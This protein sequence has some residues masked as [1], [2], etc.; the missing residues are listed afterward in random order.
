MGEGFWGRIGRTFP[1][2]K[3]RNFRLFWFGQMI[4]LVGTWIQ[5]V[6][7]GWLVLELTNNS[8]FKLG[9]VTML[10][11]LPILLFSLYAGA[12]VERHPKR[13][14]LLVTQSLLTVLAAVLATLVYTGVVQ[15]WHVLLLAF[16]LGSTN[17]FDMPAR[18]S[19]Y[20]EVV[21][22]EAL[23]SAISLNSMIFNLGR[24]LGP[25]LAA[26]LIG[27][28]GIATCFYLNAL[29]FLPVIIGLYL[30]DISHLKL[31]R[32]NGKTWEGV[33]EGL[34]YV[35]QRPSIYLAL[36]M[37]GIMSMLC[38]NFNVWIPTMAKVDL[39]MNVT[40]YGVLMTYLGLGAFAVSIYLSMTRTRSAAV[41]MFWVGAFGLA[42]F[43]VLLHFP[44]ALWVI[45]VLL[46]L[47]GASMQL[48]N[49][50]ANTT[51][52]LESDDRFRGRVMSLFSLAFLGVTPLGSL[53]AGWVAQQFGVRAAFLVS[54]LLGLFIAGAV[55][56]FWTSLANREQPTPD[57][58]P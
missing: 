1:A 37:V 53:Y 35:R 18:Q 3:Y 19:L 30:M 36:I 46:F 34:R 55:Y 23:T 58:A 16:L 31:E 29:S 48:F 21:D 40:D 45:S 42:S 6:G 38:M 43:L 51:I 4:S 7:Q 24:I 20:A 2:L 22:K 47:A 41:R 44:R 14:V 39:K 50:M 26:L 13:N 15:Y 56:V 33:T 25:G 8:A 32:R 28:L 12:V 52:Q 27:V 57:E 17:A 49:T 54:G 10:Q 5:N 11:T 9:L